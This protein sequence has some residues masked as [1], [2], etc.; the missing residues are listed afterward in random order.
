MLDRKTNDYYFNLFL[1][2]ARAT[3]M[4]LEKNWDAE[5]KACG[6]SY[7][8]QH[9]LW[10][11]HVQDGLTLEEIGNIALWNKSTTSALVSRLEKKGYIQKE[12]Q[13]GSERI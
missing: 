8:Q 3:Y 1:N 2:L 6:I 13:K 9:C 10:L 7:A 11:L 4:N 12:S 5:A